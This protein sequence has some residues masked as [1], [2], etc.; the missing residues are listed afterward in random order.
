MG[1]NTE[2]GV[3]EESGNPV[4]ATRSKNRLTRRDDDSPESPVQW[5]RAG[6]GPQIRNLSA[7]K[8]G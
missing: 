5:M 2:A 6:S 3:P 7:D 1:T 4:I 8:S